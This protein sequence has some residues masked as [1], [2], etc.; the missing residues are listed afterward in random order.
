[1]PIGLDNLYRATQ[2]T[3]GSSLLRGHWVNGDTF[4]LEDLRLGE[5]IELEYHITF[6]ATEMNVTAYHK[7]LGGPPMKLR[8]ALKSGAS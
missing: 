4:I 5:W 3:I 8:G 7:V 6:S 1:M 2:R